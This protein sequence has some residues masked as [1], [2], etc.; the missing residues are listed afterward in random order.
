MISVC[1]FLAGDGA[2][3]WAHSRG[4]DCAATQEDALKVQFPLLII[5]F[6]LTDVKSSPQTMLACDQLLSLH[7]PFVGVNLT[8]CFLNA[9]HHPCIT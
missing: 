1:S 9:Y 8:P 4:L 3:E 7:K 5:T 2:R 6:G